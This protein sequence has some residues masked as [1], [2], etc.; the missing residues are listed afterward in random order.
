MWSDAAPCEQNA[1]SCA[2]H[3]WYGSTLGTCSSQADHRKPGCSSEGPVSQKTT[4]HKGE[5]VAAAQWCPARAQVKQ[6]SG[7]GGGC[8]WMKW[9]QVHHSPANLPFSLFFQ[10]SH[11]KR[12]LINLLK[13]STADLQSWISAASAGSSQQKMSSSLQ[14]PES[15]SGLLNSCFCFSFAFSFYLSNWA[16]LLLRAKLHRAE[17]KW[18]QVRLSWTLSQPLSLDF[19]L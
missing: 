3:S 13:S 1:P 8:G 7:S 6:H 5:M 14:R 19:H 10:R 12:L 15:S 17:T 9:G 11:R 18:Q 16:E 4:K 2:E